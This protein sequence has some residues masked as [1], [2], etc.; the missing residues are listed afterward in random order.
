MAPLKFSGK[1]QMFRSDEG[2][3][4]IA[5]VSPKRL[6]DG[7]ADHHRIRLLTGKHQLRMAGD[8]VKRIEIGGWAYPV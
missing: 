6:K 5:A 1:L 3:G 8:I 4:L 7:I 2:P